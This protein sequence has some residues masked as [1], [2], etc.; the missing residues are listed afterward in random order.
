MRTFEQICEESYHQWLIKRVLS[1]L[2]IEFCVK[3]DIPAH[4][5]H[6]LLTKLEKVNDNEKANDNPGD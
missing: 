3:Q 1:K 6:K 4:E 5:V 2:T